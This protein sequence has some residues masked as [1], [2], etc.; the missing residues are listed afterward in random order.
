[1]EVTT[2]PIAIPVI[3]EP[4]TDKQSLEVNAQLPQE[5]FGL[6][7]LIQVSVLNGCAEAIKKSLAVDNVSTKSSASELLQQHQ[8][9]PLKIGLACILVRQ[10]GAGKQ[11]QLQL[12]VTLQVPAEVAD[13]AAIELNF[14]KL[15]MVNAL[16]NMMLMIVKREAII[17][18]SD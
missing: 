8:L 6:T 7:A 17:D 9:F 15:A 10:S 12:S 14:I 2:L 16:N 4:L 3:I 13:L 1:M 18:G 5:F 11:G